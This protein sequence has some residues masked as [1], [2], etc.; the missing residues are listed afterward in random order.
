M[1]LGSARGRGSGSG[2]GAV[3]CTRWDARPQQSLNRRPRPLPSPLSSGS[4]HRSPLSLSKDPNTASKKPTPSA[5]QTPSWLYQPLSPVASPHAASRVSPPVGPHWCD[6]CLLCFAKRGDR[7]GKLL[8]VVAQAQAR[9]ANDASCPFGREGEAG[10]GLLVGLL[11]GRI[12]GGSARRH[13]AEMKAGLRFRD[14]HRGLRVLD[15]FTFCASDSPLDLR[16]LVCFLRC[17]CC[18]WRGGLVWCFCSLTAAVWPLRSPDFALTHH[19]HSLT[20]SVP[21]YRLAPVY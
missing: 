7:R 13:G 6:A 15:S 12:E 11:D 19:T 2:E 17:C 18:C 10:E 20:L 8:Q 21:S 3:H 4:N 14:W 9:A 5:G 1:T 16:F